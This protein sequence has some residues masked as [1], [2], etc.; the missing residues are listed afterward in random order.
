MSFQTVL[1]TLTKATVSK[2]NM[3]KSIIYIM[4]PVGES[5]NGEDPKMVAGTTFLYE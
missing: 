3:S 4:N 5:L 2:N 1:S